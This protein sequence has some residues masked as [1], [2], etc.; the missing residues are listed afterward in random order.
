MK[1]IET[2]LTSLLLTLAL[3]GCEQKL[4]ADIEVPVLTPQ[5]VAQI[6]A[7]ND[8]PIL[9]DVRTPKEFEKGRIPGALN[10]PHKQLER[11]V[12]EISPYRERDIIVYCEKG[13]RARYAIGVL[14]KL[15]FQNLALVEGDMGEWR[16]NGLPV[17][18]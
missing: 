7:S 13:G 8:G 17:E 18:R 12:A 3:S 4:P 10:V 5:E 14:R 2:L 1:H 16:K 11:R 9:L 6:E 15:G